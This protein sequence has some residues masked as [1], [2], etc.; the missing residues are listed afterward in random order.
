MCVYL[1]AHMMISVKCNLFI[2]LV[3]GTSNFANITW[4]LIDD[5]QDAPKANE[6]VRTTSG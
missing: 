1:T 6:K 2:V 5:M 3:V 4:P